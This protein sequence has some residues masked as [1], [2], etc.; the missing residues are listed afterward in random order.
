M[1][2]AKRLY[3]SGPFGFLAVR[4]PSARGRLIDS[5]GRGS[6]SKTLLSSEAEKE[7]IREEREGSGWIVAEDRRRF[8]HPIGSRNQRA[9]FNYLASAFNN[10]CHLYFSEILSTTA[11]C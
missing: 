7:S 4:P 9:Y 10:L 3:P 6:P 11:V 5:L 1:K 8:E 2:P